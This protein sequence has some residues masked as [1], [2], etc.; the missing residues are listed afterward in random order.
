M[1]PPRL[2]GAGT[3]MST[4]SAGPLPNARPALGR[5]SART[6]RHRRP[7]Q[8]RTAM[9]RDSDTRRAV[10]GSSGLAGRIGFTLKLSCR[11]SGG[12]DA[13][14]LLDRRRAFRAEIGLLRGEGHA[15]PRH[16]RCCLGRRFVRHRRRWGGGGLPPGRRAMGAINAVC[17][18][19]LRHAGG[20]AA[21]SGRCRGP[22]R[23]VRPCERVRRGPASGAWTKSFPGRDCDRAYRLRPAW[24]F[25]RR[26]TWAGAPRR[27][28]RAAPATHAGRGHLGEGM[29]SP[30]E[31]E[32][33]TQDRQGRA[34]RSGSG[35]RGFGSI[36]SL[37]RRASRRGHPKD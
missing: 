3:A 1:L 35:T 36:G 5:I 37:S 18:T 25:R 34:Y 15:Q 20:A 32:S 16:G 9:A 33:K 13:V 24:R 17:G 11:L 7:R 31:Q 27:H 23:R 19:A 26:V 14:R 30:R 10:E 8:L 6:A 21:P 12:A 29:R 22:E 28:A 2:A 4:R